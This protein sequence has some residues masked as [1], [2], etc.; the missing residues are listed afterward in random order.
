MSRNRTCVNW[1]F[2]AWLA[3]KFGNERNVPIRGTREISRL[4][5]SPRHTWQVIK[6]L[7]Q[8]TIEQVK[9]RWNEVLILLQDA[10]LVM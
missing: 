10:F 4:T 3:T 9:A 8:L 5:Q 2:P 6:G 1:D 7:S